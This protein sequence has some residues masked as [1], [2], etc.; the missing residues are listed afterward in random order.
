MEE[1]TIYI[2]VMFGVLVTLIFLRIYNWYLF[3]DVNKKYK[4]LVKSIHEL[5]E[6]IRKSG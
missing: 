2:C 6:D 4:E 5:D 1:I 3:K